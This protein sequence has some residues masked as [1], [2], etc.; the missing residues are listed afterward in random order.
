MKG[1]WGKLGQTIALSM[2]LCASIAHADVEKKSRFQKK[3]VEQKKE[4]REYC[5]P[6]MPRSDSKGSNGII[7]PSGNAFGGGTDFFIQADAL[8][9]RATEDNLN[10]SLKTTS[11]TATNFINGRVVDA[12]YNWDWGLRGIVGFNTS[13]DNWDILAKWLWFQTRH[14]QSYSSG[15]TTNLFLQSVATFAPVASTVPSETLISAL[16]LGT[17]LRLR[18]NVGDL[19]LGRDSFI[20]K[21]VKLRP[22]VGARGLWI[23]QDLYTRTGYL[24]NINGT[25][26]QLGTSNLVKQK[27]RINCQGGGIYAGLN[28]EWAFARDWSLF[29]LFDQS[30][31]YAKNYTTFS[32]SQVAPTVSEYTRSYVKNSENVVRSI[33]DLSLGFRWAYTFCDAR[34][35][36][37]LQAAW[38][39]HL[40]YNFNEF[41]VYGRN[42]NLALSGGSFA[43]RF[44]F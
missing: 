2:V 3:K 40:F 16:N 32:E 27:Y 28:S 10:A 1:T 43:A 5:E 42:G 21:R 20:S 9:F 18:I 41:N 26:S 8:Y 35:K 17:K 38:E 31:I 7:T 29:G 37:T 15:N 11:S 30:L 14:N 33:T 36:I 4:C 39:E 25:G 23:T 13:H 24:I 6:E 12:G 34:F 44:D 19:E 22:H